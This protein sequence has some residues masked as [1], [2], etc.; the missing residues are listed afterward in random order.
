M[1]EVRKIYDKKSP[2]SNGR[3]FIPLS[4]N[5]KHYVHHPKMNPALVF[6]YAII[7][8]KYN[9]EE[10]RAFPTIDTLSVEYGMS[11]N[12]TD[13]HI[14]ILKEVG[15][16]DYPEKGSY[17]PLE[18]LEASE[19]YDRFPEAWETYTKRLATSNR[20]KERD[21]LRMQDYRRKQGYID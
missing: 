16:I 11:R 13:S 21:R 3:T 14:E 8:D 17:L 1:S 19:F 9:V 6:L 20:R 15:L 12:T 18:P 2:S 10:G 7:V 4:T 5:V